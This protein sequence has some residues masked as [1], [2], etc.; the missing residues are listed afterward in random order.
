MSAEPPPAFFG[1]N[2]T[3]NQPERQQERRLALAYWNVAVRRIQTSYSPDRPLPADPPPQFQ[4]SK[5]ETD[6]KSDGIALRARYWHRLREVWNQ[7]DAW[8]VS[9]G[10]NSDWLGRALNSLPRYVPR[11]VAGAV[12]AFVDFFDDVAQEISLH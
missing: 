5:V 6:W 11:S 3:W 1:P 4:V 8:V 2:R 9:Y 10:W 12:Q 7:R